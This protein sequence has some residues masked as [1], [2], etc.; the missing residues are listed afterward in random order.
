VRKGIVAWLL[1]TGI[2]LGLA[3]GPAWANTCP[4]LYKQCQE[5]LKKTPNKDAE[6]LCEEGIKLHEQGKHDES[7]AKL[8][9]G[10]GKLGVKPEKK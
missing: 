3:I 6:K 7:I 9:A 4:K 10:L 1:T 2:V 8:T 5:A